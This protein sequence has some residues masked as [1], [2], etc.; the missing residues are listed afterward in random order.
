MYHR[1]QTMLIVI[2]ITSTT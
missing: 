1:M 2:S